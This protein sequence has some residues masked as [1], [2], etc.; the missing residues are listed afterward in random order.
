MNSEIWGPYMWFILHLISFN[1]PKNPTEYDKQAYRDFFTSLKDILPCYNC[2][3][4][5]SKN[6]QTYPITPNLDN[7]KQFVEWLIKIHNQVNISLGK[8]I[9]TTRQVLETYKNMN[10]I[11]PFIMYDQNKVEENIKKKYIK[12]KIL[13]IIFYMD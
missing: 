4:H 12:K 9:L 10:P 6:L 1:Y 7:K 8:P 3:K 13:I 11:S 5:Y 2:K